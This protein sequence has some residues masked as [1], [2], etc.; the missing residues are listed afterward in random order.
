MLTS[1]PLTPTSPLQHPQTHP[2]SEPEQQA[3]LNCPMSLATPWA[4][5]LPQPCPP[6]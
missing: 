6:G 2:A 1:S 3:D 4:E 5:I